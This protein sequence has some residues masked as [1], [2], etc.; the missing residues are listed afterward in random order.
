[1]IVLLTGSR[2]Q[3]PSVSAGVGQ[4]I[5]VAAPSAQLLYPP[6]L[7]LAEAAAALPDASA[8]LRSAAA[9]LAPRYEELAEIGLDD[10]RGGPSWDD[11]VEQDGTA[12]EDMLLGSLALALA[13]QPEPIGFRLWRV[14]RWDYVS[15]AFLARL[16]ARPE[17]AKHLFIFDV[18]DLTAPPAMLK[19]YLASAVLP[20][21]TGRAII[22][23]RQPRP[24]NACEAVTLYDRWNPS[25][26]NYLRRG[27]LPA[28]ASDS[29]RLLGQHILYFA[30][31]KEIGRD[32][33]YRHMARLERTLRNDPRAR[34]DDIV[35][36]AVGAARLAPRVRGRGG[37][38]ASVR[39][40]QSALR[41]CPPTRPEQ[42]TKIL[43]ELANIHAVQR[44]PRSLARARYWYGKGMRQLE[45]I[46]DPE[47]RL[48]AEIRMC[49]GLALVDYHGR[50]DEQ[51][52][53]LMRRAAR[54]AA[55]AEQLHPRVGR[56]A[57][58]L[59]NLNTA[60]LLEK[61]FGDSTTASQLLDEI[62]GGNFASGPRARAGIE[63]GRLRFEAGDFEGAVDC[64]NRVL[65]RED[66]DLD[67]AE[68][69]QT[70]LLRLAANMRLTR[71]ANGAA[72]SRRLADIL[73]AYPAGAFAPL[74]AGMAR[75]AEASV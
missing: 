31:F 50:R 36:A 59:V 14:D 21:E 75:Q 11:V 66:T 12:R 72:E 57:T 63:L 48:A 47:E 4:W 28:M 53:A 55:D 41:L 40:Y 3:A 32:F 16:L 44:K 70:R 61:R 54:L 60:K 56:W 67:A 64:F 30:G 9:A 20:A 5:E 27:L 71:P 37:Y 34:P 45:A 13:R 25:G 7:D 74:L 2:R 22:P 68:E 51:A 1:M 46:R 26:W 33:L 18:W 65:Q 73:S 29:D 35:A 17:A 10:C 69:A 49:N 58:P 19:P 8:L 62:E 43:Q 24:G 38:R 42:R 52:L 39:H 6:L 23:P 15:L